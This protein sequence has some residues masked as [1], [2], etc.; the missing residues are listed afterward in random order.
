M[1]LTSIADLLKELEHLHPDDPVI[2]ANH[3]LV[4]DTTGLDLSTRPVRKKYV[5]IVDTDEDTSFM[6]SNTRYT[7]MRLEF[8]ALD[9][10]DACDT[11]VLHL[12]QITVNKH[13]HHEDMSDV[14]SNAIRLLPHHQAPDFHFG[15]NRYVELEESRETLY[16]K[17]Y[18]AL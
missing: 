1:K 7:Y 4:L 16:V 10:R 8:H 14:I 9:F 6:Y 5:L 17:P 18:S 2:R 13:G 3:Q 15:G 12:S 11:A